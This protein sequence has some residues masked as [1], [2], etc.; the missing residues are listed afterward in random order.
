MA[1]FWIGVLVHNKTETDVEN[2]MV[3]LKNYESGVICNYDSLASAL[4]KK[5]LVISSFG[6]IKAVSSNLCLDTTKFRSESL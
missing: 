6:V 5:K 1:L 2:D 3:A 4:M